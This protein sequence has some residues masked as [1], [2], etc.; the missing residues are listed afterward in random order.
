MGAD[1]YIK[2]ISDKQREKYEKLLDEAV[3]KRNAAIG[4]MAKQKAQEEVDKYYD[5]MYARG[6]FRDSYNA[7][8]LFWILGLSWWQDV[9]ESTDENAD[10][11]IEKCQELLERIKAARI[12]S[13]KVLGEYMENHHACVDDGENSPASWRK[14]FVNKKKRLVR[15]IQKAIDLNE[16]LHCSV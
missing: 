8:S 6:Y 16:P 9:G 14:Y 12:P 15:F 3:M 7:T 1:I 11:P 5:L 10:L 4:V 13:A 2:S